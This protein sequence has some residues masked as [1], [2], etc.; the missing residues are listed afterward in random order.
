MITDSQSLEGKSCCAGIHGASGFLDSQCVGC[1]SHPGSSITVGLGTDLLDGR[2]N[3]CNTSEILLHVDLNLDPSEDLGHQKPQK[4]VAT[5]RME[6]RLSSSCVVS[7]GGNFGV[8]SLDM[9]LDH[10]SAKNCI[11]GSIRGSTSFVSGHDRRDRLLSLSACGDSFQFKQKRTQN[12]V[13]LNSSGSSENVVQQDEHFVSDAQTPGKPSLDSAILEERSREIS[14]KQNNCVYK[15]RKVRHSETLLPEHMK[16]AP[17]KEAVPIGDIGSSPLTKLEKNQNLLE[18][19]VN[20]KRHDKCSVASPET[21]YPEKNVFSETYL[22]GK[23]D[24]KRPIANDQTIDSENDG[25]FSEEEILKRDDE[26]CIYAIHTSNIVMQPGNSVESSLSRR[27][28]NENCL[29]NLDDCKVHA[30]SFN[31]DSDRKDTNNENGVEDTCESSF[32]KGY[33]TA[34]PNQGSPSPKKLTCK[35][36]RIIDTTHCEICGSGACA[37]FCLD[38]TEVAEEKDPEREWCISI[39]KESKLLALSTGNAAAMEHPGVVGDG[40]CNK[41]CKVCGTLEDSISTLICDMCEES[42]HMSCCNP[43]VVSIPMKD[44]WYCTTC[45]KKRKRPVIKYSI[46]SGENEHGLKFKTGVLDK[47][48]HDKGANEKGGELLWRMLQDDGA[49]TT[50]VRIG[51]E[52][53][54]DVPI[55]TGKVTDSVESPFMGELISLEEKILEQEL[56][57]RNMENGVWPKDWKPAKFLSFGS[58]ENWLQCRAVL[59]YEGELCPDGRKAKQDI[60]CGK[61]RRAPFSQIQNDDWDCSCAVVWDPVH[62][63]CAVPQEMETEDILKLLKASEIVFPE[64]KLSKEDWGFE[65]DE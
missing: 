33:C 48:V 23:K 36:G 11:P 34:F 64:C 62:A 17:I 49:Y 55:W 6:G 5:S 39:L 13:N 46:E 58:K 54:A 59:Y 16:T 14:L 45:R 12:G 43:K 8:N 1:C 38:A 35:M 32:T 63:D 29:G 44:N 51:N 37:S 41:K 31:S 7:R 47:G 42:F 52:Y 26:R 40:K 9:S 27:I 25:N 20:C 28:V 18:T 24:G 53:Q 30:F 2:S 50:Q 4:T 65:R 61:W 3:S 22:I 19:N 56:A 15:R 21:F 60:I 57:K 10:M